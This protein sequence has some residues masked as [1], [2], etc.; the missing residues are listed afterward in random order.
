[1]KKRVGKKGRRG[2]RDREHV[3]LSLVFKVTLVGCDGQHNVL[4]TESVQVSDPLLQ[5][6]E[7]GFVGDVVHYNCCCSISVVHRK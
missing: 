6:V 2:R 5:Y 1:M 3:H 4:R 7:C